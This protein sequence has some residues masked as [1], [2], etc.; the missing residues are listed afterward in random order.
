MKKR[1]PE[2][3]LHIRPYIQNDYAALIK[4]YQTGEL[5]EEDCD[6]ENIIINKVKRDPESLLVA[7]H[8]D[9]IVGT[10]SLVEDE[11]FA[12]IFR[13]AVKSDQQRRGIGS[14]LIA[15]AEKRFKQKENTTVNILVNEK[16]L[17]LQ[18]YYER[19]HYHKGRIWRWMWKD[20]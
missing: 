17:E 18:S 5:F 8:D 9:E 1:E 12:F 4:L 11:R 20:L 2:L 16:H 3:S 6:N 13:L 10:V 7:I 15:E 19:H 14:T